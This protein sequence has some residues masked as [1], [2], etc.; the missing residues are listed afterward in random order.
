[1]RGLT[2]RAATQGVDA[3]RSRTEVL[4]LRESHVWLFD[5]F[6]FTPWYTSALAQALVCRGTKVRL[7]CSQFLRE[8]EYFGS[9]GLQPDAGPLQLSGLLRWPI[10]LK[11]ALRTS[12]VLL[13]TRA[14]LRA[15]RGG[16]EE[17]PDIIHLQQTPLLNHGFRSDFRLI[18]AAHQAGI[19]VV[20]T[21]HNLLPHDSGARLRIPYAELYRRVDHLICHSD[22]AAK[23]LTREFGVPQHRRT[24]IPHGPLFAPRQLPTPQ[25]QEA[26][27]A[28]L[29]LP[30]KRPIVLWQGV[31]A[32]YKGL[33][34]LLQAWK[35]CMHRLGHAPVAKPLL[36]IAGS[37]P[38]DLEAVI[39]QAAQDAGDSVRADLRYI[40][41]HIL[42]AYYTAADILVYPYR[43]I[44]TSGAMLTGLSYGKPIIASRLDPFQEYLTAGENA[45]LV[46]PGDAKMLA[47]ALRGLLLDVGR[48][49]QTEHASDRDSSYRQLV[50]GAERNHLR[51]TGWEEIAARTAALYHELTAC[52]SLHIRT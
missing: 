23:Q 17:L 25:D 3:G 15:L 27:R 37:G 20:H 10:F 32:E 39:R 24:V 12:E 31:L 30:T 11:R 52:N 51:Y 14:R 46:E 36:L 40:P 9:L 29:S 13:N 21:V 18:D 41:T 47:E 8:P 33:D 44:T 43:A 19:P 26:A 45:L 42:P 1:M 38:A 48:M 5:A 7:I 16:R 35:L 34:L 50:R 6:C 2:V 49:E 22:A 28:R 4:P